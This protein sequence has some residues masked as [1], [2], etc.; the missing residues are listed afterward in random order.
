MKI[1][2]KCPVCGTVTYHNCLI[3]NRKKC[4]KAKKGFQEQGLCMV[5]NE[6][7]C[8]AANFLYGEDVYTKKGD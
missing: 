1:K 3:E 4:T 2:R 7:E 6:F 8:N 5:C